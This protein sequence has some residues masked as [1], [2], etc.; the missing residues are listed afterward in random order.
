MVLIPLL[1]TVLG[2]PWASSWSLYQYGDDAGALSLD[3]M[4]VENY[5]PQP[6][7][8]QG[9]DERMRA[10][11]FW[12]PIANSPPS[13]ILEGDDKATGKDYGGAPWPAG[14]ESTLSWLG[15]IE[16]GAV[17][18]VNFVIEPEASLAVGPALGV[19]A[20]NMQSHVNAVGNYAR[21]AR[22]LL[23]ALLPDLTDNE[24]G[25]PFLV[26][27]E[28]SSPCATRTLPSI[29][30][31]PAVDLKKMGSVVGKG[32]QQRW[33]NP[34]TKQE[35]FCGFVVVANLCAAPSSYTLHLGDGVPGGITE[36]HHQFDSNYNVTLTAARALADIVP[37]YGTSILR[38][39]C[40][41][42]IEGC[43]RTG[44]AC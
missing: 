8:H 37:A 25:R 18:M 20:L 23:G 17:N 32:F 4:Q 13:Y 9:W 38:L 11:L 41:G 10:G 43:D 19:R 22:Q 5:I 26:E 31:R 2:A 1:Y 44:R 35:G 34:R 15:V 24:A 33:V 42:F 3:Y 16:F 30:G 27:I 36:A 40:E 7:Y 28:T 12:E 21:E 14:L 6:A 39:G 29:S